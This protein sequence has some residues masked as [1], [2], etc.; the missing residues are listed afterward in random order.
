MNARQKS[1]IVN[2]ADPQQVLMDYLDQLLREIPAPEETAGEV[3]PQSIE[4][5][6]PAVEVAPDTEE[7]TE[8][9]EATQPR[10]AHEAPPPAAEHVEQAGEPVQ[11]LLFDV[12]GLTMAMPLEKLCGILEWSDVVTPMPGHSP[13]FLGLLAERDAQIKIIDTAMLVVPE[14]YRSGDYLDHLEKIILIED[15]RWGLACHGVSEVIT[16][17]HDQVKWR[18][19]RGNRPWLAGTVIEHMCALLDVDEFAALLTSDKVRPAT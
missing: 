5:R 6:A 3:V 7:Q 14:R 13:W 15:G 17:E 4:V 10:V 12:A 18:A 2:F 19:T 1:N 11:I 8:V 16:L 9:A